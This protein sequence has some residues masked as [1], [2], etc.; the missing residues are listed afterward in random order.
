M[1][2]VGNWFGWYWGKK[3]A[4]LLAE[5]ITEGMRRTPLSKEKNYRFNSIINRIMKA[6]KDG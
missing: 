4:K 5:L 1:K 6:I 3:D 2:I